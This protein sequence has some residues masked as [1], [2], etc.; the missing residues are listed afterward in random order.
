M[1]HQHSAWYVTCAQ[2]I[3]ALITLPLH[4]LAPPQVPTSG[5]FFFSQILCVTHLELSRGE[6]WLQAC[7]LMLGFFQ[8]KDEFLNEIVNKLAFDMVSREVSQSSF[9]V[10]EK[11]PK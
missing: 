6:V 2:Q 3:E 8:L 10:K 4:L 5:T 7:V 9:S 1:R 11:P